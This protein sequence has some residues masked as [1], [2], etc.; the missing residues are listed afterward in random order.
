MSESTQPAGT[1]PVPAPSP[2]PPPSRTPPVQPP[3]APASSRTEPF[4]AA[5]GLPDA[6]A[7][8]LAAESVHAARWYPVLRALAEEWRTV[9][10]LVRASALSRRGVERLLDALGGELEHDGERVRIRPAAAGRYLGLPAEWAGDPARLSP[11]RHAAELAELERLVAGA[12]PP[13][14]RLDHVAATPETALRR[15]LLLAGRYELAGAHLL[16]VGDHDLTS[17][18]ATL[19]HPGLSASVVDVDDRVLGYIESSAARLGLPVRCYYADLRHRLPQA[20][21]GGADLAFTDPPYTREGV[22]LFVRRALGGLRDAR[23]RPVL[24]AY[25]ASEATPGLVQPVQ[26]TLARLGLVTEAIWPDFN[27]YDGAEAIGAASDLYLLR[28]TLRWRPAQGRRGAGPA[29]CAPSRIYTHGPQS[30]EAPGGDGAAPA[31]SRS[32]TR[33]AVGDWLAEAAAARGGRRVPL[34]DWTAPPAARG[35]AAAVDLLDAAPGALPRALLTAGADT[36]YAFVPDDAHEL[37]RRPAQRRLAALLDPWFTLRILRGTPTPRLAVV[38]AHRVPPDSPERALLARCAQA[39][40][41]PLGSALREALIAVEA[42]Q[43]RTVSKREARLRVAAAAPW[44]SGHA[45]ADLPA[46]RL[47]R[48]PSVAEELLDG[49]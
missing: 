6:L 7:A 11:E 38:A 4:A 40:F 34:V 28:G 25:G 16:C 49:R 36:V 23:Q 9:G 29:E 47:S 12:P 33:E 39:P 44:L 20:L 19:L 27:R 14:R 21:A 46:H 18:A 22:E 10:E 43:G 3:D 2:E 5:P 37:R 48:L 13:L 24:L 1:A 17:L 8:L 31:P 41:A 35:G 45:L 15:A 30:L 42:E 32:A 26:E